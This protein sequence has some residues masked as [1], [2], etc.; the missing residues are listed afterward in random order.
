MARRQPAAGAPKAL[1]RG[2]ERVHRYKDGLVWVGGEA[3]A[4]R[5]GVHRSYRL[6]ALLPDRQVTSVPA[7]LHL[8]GA[9]IRPR[10]LRRADLAAARR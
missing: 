3:G 2:Q 1:S 9:L 8:A 6:P 7:F 4:R 5:L 10:F